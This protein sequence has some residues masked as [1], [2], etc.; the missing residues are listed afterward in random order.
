MGIT[1]NTQIINWKESL[2]MT[3]SQVIEKRHL[4]ETFFVQLNKFN[5]QSIW[6]A[7]LQILYESDKFG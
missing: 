4:I 7:N 1:Y 2:S 3:L 5:N 6:N